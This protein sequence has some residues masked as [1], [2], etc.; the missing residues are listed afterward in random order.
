M[1]RQT[2]TREHCSNKEV[3]YAFDTSP[4]PVVDPPA[5]IVPRYMEQGPNRE[6]AARIRDSLAIIQRCGS[7]AARIYRQAE[8][9][10]NFRSKRSRTRNLIMFDDF[11]VDRWKSVV[12]EIGSV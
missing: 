7:K 2:P 11:N 1:I 12:V 8:C 9:L 3:S 5:E 10:T 6:E 4:R